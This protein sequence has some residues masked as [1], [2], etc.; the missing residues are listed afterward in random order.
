M[1]TPNAMQSA[2]D[3]AG[4]HTDSTTDSH[5]ID[6]GVVDQDVVTHV[7]DNEEPSLEAIAERDDKNDTAPRSVEAPKQTGG[8]A[9]TPGY[10]LESFYWNDS[11]NKAT[12]ET[13][14]R[15]NPLPDV[16]ARNISLCPTV[17]Q[18]A[19]LGLSDEDK[20]LANQLALTIKDVV[21]ASTSVDQWLA[22]VAIYAYAGEAARST[23]IA[24]KFALASEDAR[25]AGRKE[26][27][28]TLEASSQSAGRNAAII[29]LALLTAS[30]EPVNLSF[31]RGAWDAF[32]R[33][34]YK[35][36]QKF[37]NP[38]EKKA[39]DQLDSKAASHSSLLRPVK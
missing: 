17:L 10:V 12:G 7:G 21:A 29:K 27:A 20:V 15:L 35:H 6:H 22:N 34:A 28:D 33:E 23:S 18:N 19:Y 14:W 30:S 3:A 39:F 16:V 4:F 8:K 1:T 38:D 2:M 25:A 13:T 37:M 9:P 31:S 11:V 36:Q 5:D 32:G 26:N 24:V